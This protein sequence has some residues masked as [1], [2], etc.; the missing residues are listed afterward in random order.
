MFILKFH[1]IL[2]AHKLNT[3]A[4]RF[5]HRK[6]LLLSHFSIKNQIHKWRTAL[7][8]STYQ[9]LTQEKRLLKWWRKY[10]KKKRRKLTSITIHKFAN[11]KLHSR[12]A[13]IKT[14]IGEETSQ[15]VKMSHY[16][17]RWRKYHKKKWK[18]SFLSQFLY[19]HSQMKN[20]T[21]EKHYNME[22]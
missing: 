18:K 11:E 15:M 9:K 7:S 14:N 21:L 5:I 2:T 12:K 20:I 13:C 1:V 19:K 3:P 16:S 22:N 4:R 6:I 8:K 17:A 10:H